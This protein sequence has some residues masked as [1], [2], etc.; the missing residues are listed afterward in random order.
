[1]CHISEEHALQTTRIFCTHRFF[2][3]LLLDGNQL[4]DVTGHTEITRQLA[5]AVKDGDTAEGMPTGFRTDRCPVETVD[6]IE[7]LTF[8][9]QLVQLVKVT[10]TL[11]G[12]N[13]FHIIVLATEGEIHF[14]Q[15]A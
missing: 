10:I 9:H 3:E 12:I 5:F 11:V 4:C 2:L 7:F 14:V 8:H 15:R 13:V 1:M 6:G